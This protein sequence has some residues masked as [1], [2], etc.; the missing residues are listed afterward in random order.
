M[1]L[2]RKWLEEGRIS[3]RALRKSRKQRRMLKVFGGDDVA[4][5]SDVPGAVRTGYINKPQPMWPKDGNVSKSHDGNPKLKA[6]LESE[7][8]SWYSGRAGRP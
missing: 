2:E 6:N 7:G 3:P 4:N 5:T 8:S 1:S